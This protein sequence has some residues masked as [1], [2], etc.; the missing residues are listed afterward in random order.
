MPSRLACAVLLA[1]ACTAPSG[2]PAA[3]PAVPAVE[4]AA[5]AA[6]SPSPATLGGPFEQPGD[7]RQQIDHLTV[8]G[9]SRDGRYFA[10]ET[11]DAGPGAAT[12]EGAARLFVVDADSD[13]LVPGGYVE[14]RPK[15]PDAEPCDPPDLRAALAPRR[16]ALLQAHGIELGHLLAPTEPQ[17]AAATRPG[18]RAYAI[19]LPSGKTAVATLE[20]LGGDRERAHEGKG[21]AFKLD[22]TLDGQAPLPLEPG[23][24]RRPY[25]WNYD[26][27]RGLVFTSPDGTHMAVMTATTELSFE[28][29]RTSWMTNAFRLPAGW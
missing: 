4:A 14:V 5:P 23:L 18:T 25:I 10:F 26:L 2:P 8:W 22:L 24:R 1:S 9:W 17:Q 7:P 3:A 27:D 12:C 11:F 6:S 20:V 19:L 21:A 13:T 15:S 16:T 29:D 28:G